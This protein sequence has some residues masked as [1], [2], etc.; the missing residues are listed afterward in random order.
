MVRDR[1]IT[2]EF[3]VDGAAPIIAGVEIARGSTTAIVSWITDEPAD[4]LVRYGRTSTY[5]VGFVADASLGLDHQLLV[6]GLAS[7]STYHFE[8]ESADESGRTATDGDWEVPPSTGPQIRLFQGTEQAAGYGGIPQPEFNLLGNV[9]DSDGVVSLTW[10]LNGGAEQPLALGPDKFRLHLAGEFIGE[11]PY[12]SLVPGDN[13]IVLRAV[14]GVGNQSEEVVSLDFTDAV[15]PDAD[16]S[17]DFTSIDAIQDVAAVVT[18]DW[19]LTPEGMRVNSWAYDRLVAIGSLDWTDYE[20]T[21]RL[22]IHYPEPFFESPSHGPALGF[23]TRWQGHT[24]D[25]RSP[26]RQWWPLGC[27]AHLRWRGNDAG[28]DSQTFKLLSDRSVVIDTSA[29]SHIQVDT[30][31]FM[32]VSIETLPDGS[33]RHRL[34]MWATSESE[35]VEWDTDAI[36]PTGE[37]VANGSLLIVAHHVDVTFHTLEVGPVSP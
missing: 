9:S 21:A 11:I 29:G 5:E 1:S 24:P 16:I 35:P 26:A 17:I 30:E 12:A 32:K 34:K 37:D 31:Y 27:F 23:L 6:E 18:G 22:T 13:V 2:A 10:S 14:D 8:L 4:S 20:V 7:A 19:G 25:G 15:T 36:E 33:S 28:F 3:A